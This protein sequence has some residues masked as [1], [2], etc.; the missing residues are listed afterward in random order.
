MYSIVVP[1]QYCSPSIMKYMEKRKGLEPMDTVFF[2][3]LT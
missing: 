1:H 2:K 3:R